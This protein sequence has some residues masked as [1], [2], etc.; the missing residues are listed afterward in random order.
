MK[1][2]ANSIERR[3]QARILL[4]RPE[5]STSRRQALRLFTAAGLTA[6][7]PGF[8]TFAQRGAAAGGEEE[9]SPAED[10]MRE[11]GVLNRLLLVYE[12]CIS[13]LERNSELN[14]AI[15]STAA[16]V[17]RS[18]I[19]DYHEK[20]EE[21]FLFP[22]Y[23]QARVLTDLVAVLKNQHEAGRRLTDSTLQLSA[24]T[25]QDVSEKAKLVRDLKYF[26]RMY[27]PHE[28]REDTVL[29]PALRKIVSRNEYDS[30]GEEFERKEHELFGEDG[31]EAV[32][33]KVA[34]LEKQLS[35]YDLAQFTPRP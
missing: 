9:I 8:S 32:V 35:I 26:V 34:N 23:T 11:H 2:R 15:V 17:I 28:A 4:P 19:E 18:F 22:R 24:S 33:D 5:V 31:F 12:E 30:L 20:L 13:R 7:L 10:L 27:R 25:L 14:V 16:G 3:R 1:D 6:A 29:F 21:N